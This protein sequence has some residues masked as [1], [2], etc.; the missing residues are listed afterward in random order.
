MY[1]CMYVHLY[2]CMYDDTVCREDREGG[3]GKEKERVSERRER[4]ETTKMVV[5]VLTDLH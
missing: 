5:F 1:I 2:V 4:E 3:K